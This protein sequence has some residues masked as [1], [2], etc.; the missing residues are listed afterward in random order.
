MGTAFS[1]DNRSG[2]NHLNYQTSGKSIQESK[3]KEERLAYYDPRFIIGK[4][5]IG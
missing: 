4:R 2:D 5:G 3:E 1:I